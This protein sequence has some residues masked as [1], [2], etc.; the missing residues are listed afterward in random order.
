VNTTAQIE[1]AIV[2]RQVFS[3]RVPEYKDTQ[4]GTL[5][6]HYLLNE[7]GGLL[8]IA[9]TLDEHIRTLA[10]A[11]KSPAVCAEQLRSFVRGFVRPNG[12]DVPAT[13]LLADGIE[14]LGRLPKRAP[15]RS[16]ARHPGRLVPTA[17]RQLFR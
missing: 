2:G 3:V 1:A 4:D 8:R 7:S 14:A 17:V 6:F 15:M 10:T 9:D 13:P 16:P 11:L 12:L 5:H